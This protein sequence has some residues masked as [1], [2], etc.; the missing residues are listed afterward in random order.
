MTRAIQRAIA[1]AESSISPVKF[2]DLKDYSELPKTLTAL[3]AYIC[4]SASPD[5]RV[6][7]TLKEYACA[8]LKSKH[9]IL[10]NL[11]ILENK[12]YI[13]KKISGTNSRIRTYIVGS[14]LNEFYPTPDEIKA[15][16]DANRVKLQ[17]WRGD[18]IYSSPRNHVCYQWVFRKKYALELKVLLNYLVCVSYDSYEEHKMFDATYDGSVTI[19]CVYLSSLLS[20]E[21]NKVPTYLKELKQLGYIDF[22]ELQL[23]EKIEYTIYIT[24]DFK[25][26]IKLN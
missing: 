4:A 6:F 14:H 10:E 17:E 9:T 19:S 24:E 21:I 5:G 26:S 16:G 18:L 3:Y 13:I 25:K 8:V 2:T 15:K 23:T 12:F 1:Q 20:V 22:I 7:G 11:N